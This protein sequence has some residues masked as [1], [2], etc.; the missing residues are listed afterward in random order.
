MQGVVSG[1]AGPVAGVTVY[2]YPHGDGSAAL[3]ATTTNADGFYWFPGI[4]AG[5]YDV[6]FSDGGHAWITEWFDEGSGALEQS[7]ATAVELAPR[8][9]SNAS[10]SLVPLS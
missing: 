9:W 7:G 6:A 4:P 8:G 3:Y 5:S 2:L 1:P 10:A